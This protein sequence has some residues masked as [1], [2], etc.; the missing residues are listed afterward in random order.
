[1][2]KL[3]E[4]RECKGRKEVARGGAE[5][6]EECGKADSKRQEAKSENVKCT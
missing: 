2:V 6:A 4:C 5:N 1:M 3:D